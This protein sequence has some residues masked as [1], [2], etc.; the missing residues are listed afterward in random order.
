MKKSLLFIFI[1]I[2]IG[3]L[4]FWFGVKVGRHY[5]NADTVTEIHFI[6]PKYQP[7][8]RESSF[9]ELIKT[10]LLNSLRNIKHPFSDQKIDRA[11]DSIEHKTHLKNFIRKMVIDSNK[12]SIIV[13]PGSNEFAKGPYYLITQDSCYYMKSLKMIYD[14]KP[15][16]VE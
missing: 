1:A 12:Y 3:L 7:L 16:S 5:N 6:D 11:I 15:N 10:Q 2:F 8:M 4:G 13:G 9:Q 14:L